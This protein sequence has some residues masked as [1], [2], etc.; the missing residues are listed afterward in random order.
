M[1]KNKKTVKH[2]YGEIMVIAPLVTLILSL[3][4]IDAYAL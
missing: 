1:S 4:A 3:G 2:I